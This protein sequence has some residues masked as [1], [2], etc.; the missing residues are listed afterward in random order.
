[1]NK[2]ADKKLFPGWIVVAICFFVLTIGGGVFHTFGV[3][4]KPLQDYF[5]WSRG[6]TSSIPTVFWVGYAISCFVMGQLTDRYG[7]RLTLAVGAVLAGLGF[8]LASQTTSIWQLYLFYFMAALGAGATVVLPAATVQR[9]FIR[10]RGFALGLTLSGV[11]LGVFVGAPLAN[12]L[13]SHYDWRTAYLVLGISV[14]VLLTLA[15]RLL[16]ASPEVKGLRPYGWHEI[17]SKGEGPAGYPNP[18]KASPQVWATEELSIRKTVRTRAFFLTMFFY[19]VSWFPLPI[20][21]VHFIPFATDMGISSAV[22][23]SAFGLMGGLIIVGRIVMGGVAD[24][25]GWKTAFAICCLF[26]AVAFFWLIEVRNLWMLYFFVVIFGFAYG[27]LGTQV[28]GLVAY[29]LG[30]KSLGATTGI[31]EGICVLVSSLSPLLAGFIFDRTG[32]YFI[33][34]LIGAVLLAAVGLT[35]LLLK[36][37]GRPSEQQAAHNKI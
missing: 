4:F 37:P 9:W 3:F 5:G 13:I 25:L 22:A 11:G 28:M 8:S 12:Y 6:L 21:M 14:W 36:S 1:M 2:T 24:K 17:Q 30:M 23:A 34:F 31:M 29:F 27:G 20:V 33:A 15:S 18:L 35:A 19:S 32:G 16:V 7:P 26:N 10:R